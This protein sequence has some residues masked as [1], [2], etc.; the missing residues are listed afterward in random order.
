MLNVVAATGPIFIVVAVGFVLT[1]LGWFSRAD[2][3]VLS[4]FVV[5]VALP[6]LVFINI[7]GRSPADILQS[8]YLLTY[9]GA[10]VVMF[11]LAHIYSRAA[12]RTSLRAAVLSVGMA[13]TNNGFMGLPI[14]LILFADWAGVA[15]G[16]D[17]LV[18][19]ILILPVGLFLMSRAAGTGTIGERIRA[20]IRGVVLHPLLIAI[21]S[22]LVL[23]GLGLTIPEV[24]DR[25]VT[26][27][28]QASAGVALFSVGGMLVGLRVRG[29]MSDILVSVAGKLLVMP[30]VAVGLLL[31]FASVGMPELPVELRAA[32]VLTCALP[33]YSILPPLAEQYGEEDV[34]TASMLLGTALSFLTI[35]AWMLVLTGMGWLPAA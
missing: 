27:M 6:L 8:T 34:A 19:N 25:S 30:A 32:A 18:D 20:T 5:K 9:A 31:V 28:A 2:M 24:L 13:G 3:S 15:V 10:A 14:F 1:R 35:S 4:R 33:T 21:V 29:G 22:A 23:N 7:Y 26:L 16:M 17:M 11:L 12:G